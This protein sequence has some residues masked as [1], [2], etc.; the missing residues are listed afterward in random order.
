MRLAWMFV[1]LIACDTAAQPTVPSGA[2]DAGTMKPAV[3]APLAPVVMTPPV[4]RQASV[5]DTRD[6]AIEL[7]E[8]HEYRELIEKLVRPAD[9]QKLTDKEGGVERVVA[10]FGQ[11]EKPGALLD[12]LRRTRAMKPRLEEDGKAARFDS[13]DPTAPHG[14]VT[15]EQ[16]EGRWYLRN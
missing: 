10:E 9:L 15:F 7:L 14:G 16:V 13:D 11:S 6:L 2:L 8:K 4:D 1:L 5:E 12:M 3:A